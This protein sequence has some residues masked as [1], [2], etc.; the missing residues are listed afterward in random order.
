M[1]F[2]IP[3]PLRLAIP[4]AI[5]LCFTPPVWAGDAANLHF[6]GFSEEG[7]YLAFQEYGVTDGEGA[8]YA[9]T[10]F[11][12]V[13]SNRYA[14]KPVRSVQPDAEEAA[15]FILQAENLAA[16]QDELEKLG[17][18]S[19]KIGTQVIAN[20]IHELS[21]DPH[22]QRFALGLP[23]AG[24]PYEVYKL[25]LE[26]TTGEAECFGLGQAKQFTLT[27]MNE[28]HQKPQILQAD[29]AIPKS[30]GCPL[31]YRI[32]EVYVHNNQHLVVF[33]NVFKPGFEGQN[34][35]F[36]AVSAALE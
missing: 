9:N 1:S 11:L 19:G 13:A 26:E 28:Y 24:S 25:T 5:L 33:L 27:V 30:R 2:F 6:I 31:G 8:A 10:F 18:A 23:L 4:F 3:M 36:M 32:Q 15:E 12:E 7:K 14:A 21:A 29:K 16:A 20:N 22:E 34:M 17:I 35:R